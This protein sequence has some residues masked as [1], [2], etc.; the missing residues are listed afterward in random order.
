MPLYH[1]KSKGKQNKINIKSKTLDKRK[2]K[3]LVSRAFHN[4]SLDDELP[5]DKI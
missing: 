1:P 2:E 5:E 3:L 4:R